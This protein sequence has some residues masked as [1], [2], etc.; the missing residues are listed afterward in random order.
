MAQGL[1]HA[2]R[3]VA[4]D[5]DGIGPKDGGVAWG[6]GQQ[7]RYGGINSGAMKT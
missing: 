5:E 6:R 3:H 4:E 1:G 2:R 7:R